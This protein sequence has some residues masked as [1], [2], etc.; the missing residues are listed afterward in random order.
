MQASYNPIV[1]NAGRPIKVVK[2]ATEIT[3]RKAAVNEL[4]QVLGLLAEGD[5]NCEID[6][7]FPGELDA[8]RQAFNQ[9]V[10]R[11]RDIVRQLR[12]TSGALRAA[13]GEILSGANDLASRTTRQATTIEETSA[14]VDQLS[15]TV[16]Q[17]A[18][19]ANEARG[20]A[21]TVFDGANEAGA[22]MSQAN[23]AMDEVTT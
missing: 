8:V 4:G 6:G 16:A 7:A 20:K 18:G 15:R 14:A 12:T 1:D 5:L 9:T 3:A 23:Q 10:Q 13:T 17:N 19:R 2:F 21:R 22:V 11:L